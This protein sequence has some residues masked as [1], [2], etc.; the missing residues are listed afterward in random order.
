MSNLLKG[1]TTLHDLGFTVST[2]NVV[3]NR[4]KQK[5][6]DF[7]TNSHSTR[8]IYDFNIKNNKLSFESKKHITKKPFLSKLGNNKMLLVVNRGSQSGK[9][10]FNFCL[11]DVRYPY[12]L[13]NHL[14]S[15]DFVNNLSKA[16]RLFLFKKIIKSFHKTKTKVFLDNYL[17]TSTLNCMELKHA[18][19]IYTK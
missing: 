3:W 11:I 1:S 18:L 19:P 15:I 7:A 8:L 14:L 10:Q 6:T 2:G 9:Y 17:G 4:H 13:E 5:L 16:K 12:L